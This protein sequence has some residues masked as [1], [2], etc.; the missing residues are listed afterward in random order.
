MN[1]TLT[2]INQK[3][4]TVAIQA[5]DG[6]ILEVGASNNQHQHSI[7]LYAKPSNISERMFLEKTLDQDLEFWDY[8]SPSIQEKIFDL[9]FKGKDQ[10]IFVIRNEKNALAYGVISID[11]SHGKILFKESISN[12]SSAEQLI[13]DIAQHLS[14][15]FLAIERAKAEIL[16]LQTN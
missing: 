9:A 15:H 13:S 7:E 5:F 12:R 4:S 2:M 14:N 1:R 8:I 6:I 16:G 3:L 10:N 11:L